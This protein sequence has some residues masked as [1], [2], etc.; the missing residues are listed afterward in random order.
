MILAKTDLQAL[1]QARHASPHAVLGM[2]PHRRGRSNGVV[3][4]A[5]VRHAEACAV[6]E[7]GGD[8]L[9]PMTLLGPAFWQGW[10]NTSSPR[11]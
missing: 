3:V 9:W 1:L 11:R 10:Y 8:G 6:A 5:L 2:H 4:R 7:S